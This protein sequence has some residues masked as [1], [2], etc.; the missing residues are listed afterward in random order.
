MD[1]NLQPKRSIALD[2]L[3]ENLWMI[4][5]GGLVA[6]FYLHNYST[7]NLNPIQMFDKNSTI[8]E[9]T[10]TQSPLAYTTNVPPVESLS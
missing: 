4:Q 7:Q 6:K 3:P 5:I 2:A 8:Q 1:V 10:R 9:V